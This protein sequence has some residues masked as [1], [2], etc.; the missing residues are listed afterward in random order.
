MYMH[1][2]VLG[3]RGRKNY[4]VYGI[5]VQQHQPKPDTQYEPENVAW[6]G[7]Y[8]FQYYEMTRE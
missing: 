4:C 5:K 3:E 8:C 6:S 2:Y 7:R 1:V